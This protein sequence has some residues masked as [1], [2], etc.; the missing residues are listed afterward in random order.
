M[1]GKTTNFLEESTFDE[2]TAVKT[3]SATINNEARFIKKSF[4]Y[5]GKRNDPITKKKMI[6]R[7]NVPQILKHNATSL[8]KERIIPRGKPIIL[9]T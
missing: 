7:L 6:K 3:I 5:V 2:I 8:Y 1:K 4:S 9:Y